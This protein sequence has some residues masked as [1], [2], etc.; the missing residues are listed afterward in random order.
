MHGGGGAHQTSGGHRT[1]VSRGII[2][3]MTA[4]M[5][6]E[7]ELVHLP[8]N[9]ITRVSAIYP[10]TDAEIGFRPATIRADIAVLSWVEKG[11]KMRV[12]LD[13]PQAGEDEDGQPLMLVYRVYSGGRVAVRLELLIKEGGHPYF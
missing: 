2:K 9:F 7:I 6:K 4:V 5:L 11:Q 8:T 10:K 1:I 12:Q 3:N 13:I